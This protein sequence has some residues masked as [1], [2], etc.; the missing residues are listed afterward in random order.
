[1][2]PRNPKGNKDLDLAK[3]VEL[4]VLSV[5]ERA[6]RC[7]LLGSDR[8]ITLRAS[9]L[10]EVAPG[11]ILTVNPQKQWRYAGHPYLSGE[12]VS[13]RI[14]VE[15]LD[16]APLGL[17]DMGIWDPKE[18]YWR[19]E[20]E[21]VEAWAKPIIARGPRSMFEMEQVAPAENAGDP[22]E[23]PITRSN[24]LINAGKRAEAVKILMSLCQADL[25]CLDAHS[26]LGN[27]VFDHSPQDAI[28]HYEVGLRIGELS[29]GN[30]F[31]GV[32]PWGFI[33]NRP[34]L[35]CMQGYGLC[36]WRL[37]RF[38]EA[39]RV[40]DRMLWLNP[41]DNQGVRFLIDEVKA[42][43]AWEDRENNY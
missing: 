34:F 20:N 1:M 26:H 42:K 39:E 14:D 37:G 10:W 2:N 17:A 31:T 18:D 28:R 3:L 24:D 13:I 11:A 27:I 8:V 38:D 7:R 29:L 25:R 30:G 40:F 41:S 43:T 21:P 5:K 35:R 15:A 23:D 22:F 9:R 12:I 6:A 36:L 33:D 16:L 4:A 19:E 32:L